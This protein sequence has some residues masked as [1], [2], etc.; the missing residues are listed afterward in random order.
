MALV[1]GRAAGATVSMAATRQVKNSRRSSSLSSSGTQELAQ[2]LVASQL[3]TKVPL[4]YPAAAETKVNGRDPQAARS[5][6]S[7][8]RT[9]RSGGT[10]GRCSLVRTKGPLF[11]LR[12]ILLPALSSMA[13]TARLPVYPCDWAVSNFEKC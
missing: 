4:P 10:G 1:F 5:S 9:T 7:R 8:V 12:S 6:S 11:L 13:A 3:L 2:S